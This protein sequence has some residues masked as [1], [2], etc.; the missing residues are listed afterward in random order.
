V[1]L[2]TRAALQADVTG[3]LG[4]DRHQRGQQVRPGYRNGHGELHVSTT[5]GPLVLERPR[6]RG[7]N[8]ALP[9]G[10]WARA[11]A[12]PMRRSRWCRRGWC[13]A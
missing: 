7:T 4:R 3:F 2:V 6:L 11:S 8:E 12:T 5:A 9:C 13:V 1:R 10:C